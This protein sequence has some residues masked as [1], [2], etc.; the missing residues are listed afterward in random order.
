MDQEIKQEFEK[1]DQGID[2]LADVV[3]IGFGEADKK[4]DQKIDN[5]AEAVK[6]GFDEM[7]EK[8]EKVDQR[9]EKVD[10]R[11]EKIDQRFEKIDER[12]D[13]L[14]SSIA[15]LH[16]ELCDIRQSLDAVAKRTIEDGDAEAKDILE[17]RRRLTIAEEQIRQ[18]QTGFS[19]V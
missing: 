13:T 7:N 3:R 9:F 19:G 4:I 10:Q 11:F 8:F 6:A 2:K 16:R 12:F 18:L 15:G 1:I 14:E 5:L 17:L